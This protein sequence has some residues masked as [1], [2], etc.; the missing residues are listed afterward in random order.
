M[1]FSTPE[2]LIKLLNTDTLSDKI[3][4]KFRNEKSISGYEW[5]VVKSALQKYIRRNNVDMALK[6]AM[7]MYCFDFV[8]GGQ[9]IITNGLHRLQVIFLE[10]IGG[11]NINLWHTL[12]EWFDILFQE[13]V[14]PANERNRQKEIHT[15]QKIVINLCKSKKIRACSFMNAICA[16]SNDDRLQI[17]NTEYTAEVYLKEDHFLLASRLDDCLREK[18]WQSIRYLREL[19]RAIEK[20][21]GHVKKMRVNSLHAVVDKY[22]TFTAYAQKWK[23][24]IG[25]LK[26]GYILYFAQLGDYLYGSDPLQLQEDCG[27]GHWDF[28]MIGQVTL[29]D[30]VYDKHVKNA[31]NNTLGYFADV[32][33]FVKPP[34]EN[35]AIPYEFEAI[36]KWKKHNTGEELDLRPRKKR[37][38]WLF[39]QRETQLHFI[40]RA[41]INTSHSKTDTYFAKGVDF[42]KEQLW[43]VKGPYI[44]TREIEQFMQLQKLKKNLRMPYI[45][46][47]LKQMA[48]DLFPER[49]G[50]GLRSKFTTQDTGYFMFSKSV[51]TEQQL[52]FITHPATKTW[53]ETQVV[54]LYKFSV[55]V[56][57]LNDEQLISYMNNVAFRV[58]YNIGD[59]ADRNFIL[60]GDAVFSV[61]ETITKNKVVLSKQIK[62]A[63]YTHLQKHFQRL[64]PRLHPAL[65]DYLRDALLEQL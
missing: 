27:T 37:T 16:L 1:H 43:L 30:F 45:K 23:K 57:E 63:R 62:K 25:H 64:Q 21:K 36:Y 3:S 54:D 41:Q 55:N 35:V 4:N 39:P 47:F 40:C 51:V 31:I 24:D 28:D 48:V 61:D 17:K 60:H 59:M 34:A 49:P 5:N 15:L 26:E 52:H 11:G 10:D 6:M 20:S 9:R 33:S 53:P 58:R 13:R 44:E 18:K 7:E 29:D 65:V 50:I 38:L 12:C 22:F 56:F 46:C 19:L 2:E 42:D 8:D 14:K 32:S